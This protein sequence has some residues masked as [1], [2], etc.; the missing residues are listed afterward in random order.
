[1]TEHSNEFSEFKSKLKSMVL[2]NRNK[3]Q[4]LMELCSYIGI[5]KDDIYMGRNVYSCYN[6]SIEKR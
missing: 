4:D 3:N 1:M 2:G 6:A 5:F